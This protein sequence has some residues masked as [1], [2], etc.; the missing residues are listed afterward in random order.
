MSLKV[1]KNKLK[2]P[3]HFLSIS[4]PLDPDPGSVFQKWIH[5]VTESGSNMDPD[6]QP[7]FQQSWRIRTIFAG[8]SVWPRG[9]NFGRK[10]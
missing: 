5:K 2:V 4:F 8:S 1:L 7:C 9:R 6:H 10:T 3:V